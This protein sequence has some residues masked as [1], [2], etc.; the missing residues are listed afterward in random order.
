MSMDLVE[1]SEMF[2]LN[3]ANN[4]GGSCLSVRITA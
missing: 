4:G 3:A 1:E 2:S